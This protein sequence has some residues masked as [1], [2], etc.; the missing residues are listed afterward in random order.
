MNT[1]MAASISNRL[2]HNEFASFS[3]AVQR[4]RI[5]L[6]IEMRN[7][8]V[9]SPSAEDFWGEQIRDC[10]RA[11]AIFQ[12][13]PKVDAIDR[14]REEGLEQFADALQCNDCSFLAY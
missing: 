14:M 10:D 8:P 13:L 5:A 7:D 11:M 12:S 6:Q 4:L 9:N 1:A 3:L 2:Y